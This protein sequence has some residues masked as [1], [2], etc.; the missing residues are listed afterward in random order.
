[1]R[2]KVKAAFLSHFGDAMNMRAARL[3]GA[4]DLQFVILYMLEER[5]RHGYEIIK[6]IAEQSS[7]FYTPSP[8]V[9][10][11]AL[12]YLE[13]TGFTSCA[14]EGSRKL[15]TLTSEGRAHLDEHRDEAKN[16]LANMARFGR[17]VQRMREHF[18]DEENA[19]DDFVGNLKGDWKQMKREFRELKDELKRAIFEKLD[20]PVEEKRRVLDVLRRAIAEIRGK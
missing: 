6:A 3:M 9:I 16:T 12:T 13:E 18:T 8:G 15:Y 11:P 14:T 4:A 1:M 5:P 7:G 2:H 19:A 20:A 17:K 10:Y